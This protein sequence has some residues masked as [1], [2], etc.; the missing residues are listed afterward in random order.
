MK[1]ARIPFQ[2]GLQGSVAE[3]ED[4]SCERHHSAEIPKADTS[5]QASILI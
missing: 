2:D 5:G 3:T 1:Q 4:R